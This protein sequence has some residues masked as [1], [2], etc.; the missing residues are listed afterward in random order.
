[1]TTPP[2]IEAIRARWAGKPE[3]RLTFGGFDYWQ[4]HDDCEDCAAI[5]DVHALLAALDAATAERDNWR[6]RYDGVFAAVQDTLADMRWIA[7]E[8]DAARAR[9]RELEGLRN[10]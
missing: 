5:E 9:V 8:R 3:E 1:M 2:D 10:A 7:A 6:W 4:A